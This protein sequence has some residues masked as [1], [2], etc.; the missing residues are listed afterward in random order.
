MGTKA[1]K[2]SLPRLSVEDGS[3]FITDETSKLHELLI[4]NIPISSLV[5]IIILYMGALQQHMISISCPYYD[6]S[7]FSIG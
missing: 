7:P 3:P 1:S 5:D 2:P 4:I 6:W